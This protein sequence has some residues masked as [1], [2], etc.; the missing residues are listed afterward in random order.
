M[1]FDFHIHPGMKAQFCNREA[2][3]SNKFNPWK[4]I[5]PNML[6]WLH[7][8]FNLDEVLASQ[9]S[10]SQL[11]EHKLRLACISLY[12]PE[13]SI[14]D[15]K[16]F[17]SAA[18]NPKYKNLL[19]KERIDGL[20]K[21]QPSPFN[22]IFD[23]NEEI[24]NILN[25]QKFGISQKVKALNRGVAYDEADTETIFTVFTI[26][27]CHTLFNSINDS[28]KNPEVLADM[29]IENLTKL[30]AKIPVVALVITHLEPTTLGNHC[31]GMQ[32]FSKEVDVKKF[33][34]KGNG[35]TKAAERIINFCYSK[36][37]LVD[38]KHMSFR[39]RKRLYE[40]ARAAGQPVICTHAGLTGIPI[41][42]ANDFIFS[43]VKRDFVYKVKHAKPLGYFHDTAFN[44]STINLYNQDILEIL[45]SGG[46]IG[47]SLDRRIL[48]FTWHE[49]EASIDEILILDEDYI[50][51]HEIRDY[52]K[53]YND[54][55]EMANEQTA[56]SK[57]NLIN[58]SY[59]GEELRELHFHHFLNHV[60]H[61][62]NIGQQIQPF[63]KT[64]KQICLGSDFDGII[65]ATFF[66]KSVDDYD[67]LERKFIETFDDNSANLGRPAGISAEEIARNIFYNN[68]K[69]FV[70]ERL[71]LM[72]A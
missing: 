26:E 50:S 51:E 67:K 64:M 65:S 28:S 21:N 44:A 24:D 1:Y 32:M 48:G 52:L 34:P 42:E 55:G 71:R 70:L 5:M 25:P 38:C 72:H 20:I 27:G 68:G 19:D 22:E 10:F 15:S 63:E 40:I 37:I 2:I 49:D 29:V 43:R 58:Y 30:I 66:A 45:R 12:A 18:K 13:K 62:F 6:P 47:I 3:T 46:V 69:K 4:V 17:K 23:A 54:F 35:I 53:E 14:I 31:F 60:I 39:G 8:L 41:E 9:A 57:D 36:N 7:R 11:H 59:T 61:I 33:W 56:L 16:M